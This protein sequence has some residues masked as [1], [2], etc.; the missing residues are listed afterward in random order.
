MFQ[1]ICLIIRITSSFNYDF[2]KYFERAYDIE[3]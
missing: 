3:V 2:G 1:K